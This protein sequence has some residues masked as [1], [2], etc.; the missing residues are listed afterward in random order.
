MRC[1]WP[2]DPRESGCFGQGR[3]GQGQAPG[4]E[5]DQMGKDIAPGGGD[6]RPGRVGI[7]RVGQAFDRVGA[8]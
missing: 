7:D 8:A 4:G 2:S 3:R 5:V 6:Q 1:Q